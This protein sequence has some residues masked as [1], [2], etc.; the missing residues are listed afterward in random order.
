MK[1]DSVAPYV[2]MLAGSAA[3]SVMGALAHALSDTLDWQLIASARTLFPLVVVS[4][5]ALAAGVK[6]V[7]WRPRVLWLRS[8]AGSFSLVCAFYAFAHLPVS[9]VQTLTNVFPVWVTLLSWFALRQRPT[10][11]VVLAVASGVA[12]VVL[13]QE[14]HLAGGNPAS[15]V[16]LVSSVF[17]AVAMVG[18]HR[19]RGLDARAVVV[20]FSLVSFAFSLAAW[21]LFER[22]A[23]EPFTALRGRD[24]GIFLGLGVAA[25]FG[26]ICLTRAFAAGP[27]AKVSV[28]CL[29]QIVFGLALDVTFLGHVPDGW[30]LAGIALVVAPTAWLLLHRGEEGAPP[31][32]AGGDPGAE[33]LPL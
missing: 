28:V 25:T 16:A 15:L 21:A 19:L 31:E 29:T 27:P 8:L 13:I 5:W 11:A 23:P 26:Q 32:V 2:W 14:R 6:L 33:G 1:A 12:G 10:A 17:T 4:A 24:L 18:L 20:H 9:D 22:K 3:F 7:L 30:S